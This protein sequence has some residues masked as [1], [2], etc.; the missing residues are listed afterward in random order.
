M[1][2]TERERRDHQSNPL[3]V[4][5]DRIEKSYAGVEGKDV[6]V[7]KGVSLDIGE[8][9]FVALV[10]E[11]GAG[12]S[13]LLHILGGLDRPSSG[14]VRWRGKDL[15]SMEDDELAAF[16]NRSVGFV[17]QFHHLLPEFSAIENVAM[18]GLIQQKAMSELKARAE[19]LLQEI[20]LSHRL[21]HRPSELSGGEQQRVAFA[22]ALMNQPD[23][24]LADEPS[25]NLDSNTAE[26]LH[27]QMFEIRN[28]T[29]V[30]FVIATH[31]EHL[32]S[33]ADRI[34]RIE[35]GVII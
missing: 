15:S 30:S 1:S 3:L 5:A 11:S 25:G 17:F 20:G 13:T 6:V 7:L 8:G 29:G 35:D 26:K 23:L 32:A 19:E 12:K 10:G 31:N 4:K 33:N 16:R 28:K 2:Q 22:R 24:I 14:T 21:E 18:P 34:I 27:Q 9:E